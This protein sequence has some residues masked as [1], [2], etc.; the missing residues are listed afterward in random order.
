MADVLRGRNLRGDP[1]GRI[2][3]PPR[4]FSA[5]GS[6]PGIQLTHGQQPLRDRRGLIAGGLTHHI[7]EIHIRHTFEHIFDTARPYPR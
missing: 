6:A 3:D 1:I 5:L 2:A 4:A 7:D